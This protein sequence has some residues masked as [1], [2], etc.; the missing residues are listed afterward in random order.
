LGNF[1]Y[2]AFCG[3]LFGIA[4]V[5]TRLRGGAAWRAL[6]GRAAWVLLGFVV[7][8]G[9]VLAV[10]AWTLTSPEAVVAQESAPGWRYQTL[11]ATDLL[12]FF[13][14]GDYYFPDNRKMGNFG[15]IH[16]NYLGWV[17][18]LVALFGVTRRPG[19]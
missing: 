12:T 4:L 2:A 16:V 6:A 10:A 5:A 11:P 1:Y 19:F 14:P 8:A 3:L 15:I 9:P 7:L 13:R 17:T 18:T